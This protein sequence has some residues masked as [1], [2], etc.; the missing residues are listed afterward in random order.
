MT[1]TIGV[2][3]FHHLVWF[4]P[5]AGVFQIE[6]LAIPDGMS[7]AGGC[8]TGGWHLVKDTIGTHPGYGD[9]MLMLCHFPQIRDYTV[10]AVNYLH[11]Q[12]LVEGKCFTA[13]PGQ[14]PRSVWSPEW[15]PGAETMALPRVE[16]TLVASQEITAEY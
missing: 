11:T 7:T 15:L 6:T 1:I 16:R 13:S 3:H 4:S 8:W 5:D 10:F 9:Q 12:L 2:S 14:L